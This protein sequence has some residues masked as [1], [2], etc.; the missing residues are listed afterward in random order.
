LQQNL[1]STFDPS[2]SFV[3]VATVP[4][5]RGCHTQEKSL[6]TLMMR[7]REAI[8]LR[9]E[10]EGEPGTSRFPPRGNFYQAEYGA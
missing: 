10:I 5:L 1:L 2:Q 8:E 3:D 6:D 4:E 9:L 7:V